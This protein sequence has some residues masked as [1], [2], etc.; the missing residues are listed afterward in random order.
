M[1]RGFAREPMYQRVRA[2]RDAGVAP[3]AIGGPGGAPADGARH[4][5]VLDPVDDLGVKRAG[6]LLEWRRSATGG[7]WE[8][9]VVYVAQL[10]AR[11][12]VS[13]EEWLSADRL[14]PA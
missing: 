14:E 5:W 8:G 3:G 4:C 10:R 6:L 11:G 9:R 13:V 2:G 12:W 1:R 7:G